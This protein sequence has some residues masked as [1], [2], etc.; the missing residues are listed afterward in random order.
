MGEI[1]YDKET[2]KYSPD[3]TEISALAVI[4]Q[5]IKEFRIAFQDLVKAGEEITLDELIKRYS[6]REVKVF[7]NSK[8]EKGE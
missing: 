2:A 4:Y 3:D 8:K 6:E 7:L 1:R 5:E